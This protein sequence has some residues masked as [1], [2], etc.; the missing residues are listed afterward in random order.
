MKKCF[1]SLIVFSV[2]TN[3]SLA[4]DMEEVVV[5][6]SL[7]DT[8]EI[9]NPLYVIDGNEIN[10]D[11]TTSLGDAVD[12]YLG[13]SIADYGS[14]VGQPIIRG[15]SGS[16]VR[17]LENGV[18]VRDVGTLDAGGFI[19]RMAPSR[20]FYS[21]SYS[22]SDYTFSAVLKDVA[23]HDNVAEEN[24]MMTEGY[25]MLNLKLVKDYQIGKAN[26]RLAAFANNAL[27]Q[28]AR[29]STSFV[30]DAVPLPGRNV[31]LSFRLTY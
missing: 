9:T 7:V 8:S 16:R 27:D 31:G 6:S 23:D 18:V 28:V 14:A 13:V 22:E 25:K 21:A 5:T 29:N 10:D 12:S 26:L 20:N 19:P 4:Q 30:K 24:E 11:I 3:I 15:M 2:F 1:F 17:I